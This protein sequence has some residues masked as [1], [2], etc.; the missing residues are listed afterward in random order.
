MD[1]REAVVATASS[2]WTSSTPK[3]PWSEQNPEECGTGVEAG[4]WSDIPAACTAAVK[5][6]GITVPD[7]RRLDGYRRAYP[8]YREL[9]PGLQPSFD[10]MSA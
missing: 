6:T 10:R 9:Y 2:P 7:L 1:D 4:L 3:L 5:S 8:L